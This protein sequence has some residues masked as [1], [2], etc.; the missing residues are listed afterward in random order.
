MVS[1]DLTPTLTQRLHVGLG[2]GL[3]LS[4][5]YIQDHHF[6]IQISF[7]DEFLKYFPQTNVLH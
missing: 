7:K 5:F 3:G 1:P 4:D 2:L 6:L